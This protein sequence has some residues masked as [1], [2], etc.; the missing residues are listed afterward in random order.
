MT[1]AAI[2]TI[3]S[4]KYR[5]LDHFETLKHASP[6]WSKNENW[7]VA[8]EMTRDDLDATDVGAFLRRLA[9]QLYA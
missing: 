3:K 8:A 2:K 6:H 7:R 9:A 5:A 4:E 1:D